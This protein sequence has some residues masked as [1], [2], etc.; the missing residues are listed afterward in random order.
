MAKKQKNTAE[1][2]EANIPTMQQVVDFCKQHGKMVTDGKGNPL[3]VPR[4]PEQDG[5]DPA[6]R[7]V[8][9]A[10]T[11]SRCGGDG[12]DPEIVNCTCDCCGGSGEETEG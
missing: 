4:D 9:E 12:K 2:T 8:E 7:G 10:R 11:C 6:M 1:K 3:F 5:P